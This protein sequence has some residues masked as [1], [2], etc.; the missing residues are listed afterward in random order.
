MENDGKVE[1][2]VWHLSGDE[3]AR[4]KTYY[5]LLDDVGGVAQ[6]TSY[7]AYNS[8]SMTDEERRECLKAEKPYS[9]SAELL[10]R[11]IAIELVLLHEHAFTRIQNVFD[12]H[13]EPDAAIIAEVLGNIL[14]GYKHRE[15][16]LEADSR[17]ER[18]GDF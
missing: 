14:E 2:K 5:T 18:I 7:Q 16:E 3:T 12:K 11:L 9:V 13:H 1:K 15:R 10:R 6:A 4:L 17:V 8:K